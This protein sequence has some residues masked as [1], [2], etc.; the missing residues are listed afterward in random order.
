MEFNEYKREHMGVN[1]GP[2]NIGA[3]V[4]NGEAC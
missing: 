1:G 4:I 3:Y 2:V